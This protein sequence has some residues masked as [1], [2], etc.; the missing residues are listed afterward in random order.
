[1]RPRRPRRK[2]SHCALAAR[3][4]IPRSRNH[5]A[6]A[7]RGRRKVAGARSALP[8]DGEAGAARRAEQRIHRAGGAL[9]DRGPS[10]EA[11]GGKATAALSRSGPPPT[12]L[13]LARS[14]ATRRILFRAFLSCCT[15]FVVDL[16][17]LAPKAAGRLKSRARSAALRNGNARRGVQ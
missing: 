1:M 12:R 2:P 10:A 4:Y 15:I 13:F 7:T 9:R 6:E 17:Q 8:G 11:G 14:V 16:S 5:G 3:A